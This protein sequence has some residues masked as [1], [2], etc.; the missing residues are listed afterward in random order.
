[1]TPLRRLLNNLRALVR[2]RRRDDAELSDELRGY[3]DAAIDAKVAAGLTR[4]DAERAAR[5]EIGSAAA[6]RDRVRDVGWGTRIDDLW[7]DVRY[8]VRGF[9]RAPVFTAFALV[10]LALG[11]GG[12]TAVFSVVDGVLLKP[13]PYPDPERLV[14]VTQSAQ[15][16]HIDDLP[17]SPSQYFV[18]RDQNHSV[19][20]VGLYTDASATITGRGAPDRVDAM[21]VTDGVLRSSGPFRPWV[22]SSRDL[23]SFRERRRPSSSPTRIGGMRSIAIRL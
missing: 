3:L 7:R 21:Q 11:I 4:A 17:V 12:T 9:R 5:V 15:T 13:L 10:T 1:M 16:P 19:T 18:F 8:A 2:G 14:D 23:T 6:I 20:D 22:V